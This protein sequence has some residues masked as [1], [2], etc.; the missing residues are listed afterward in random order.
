M[1][2]TVITLVL[3]S[4]PLVLVGCRGS[5]QQNSLWDDVK[6]GDLDTTRQD[7]AARAG[8]IK[9]NNFDVHIYEIPADN[10][11]R[12]AD[13]WQD[14]DA[15][16]MRFYN[17]RAFAENHFRAGLGRRLRWSGIE[18]LIRAA[19]GMKMATIALLLGKT[20]GQ[21]LRI[22]GFDNPLELTFVDR[23]G[24]ID[25]KLI[26]P[27]VFGLRFAAASAPGR[28]ACE[29]VGYPVFSVPVPAAEGPM[30]EYAKSREIEFKGAGFGAKMSK[31]DFIVLGPAQYVGELQT[32][33]GLVFTNLQGTVFL[34]KGRRP[35]RNISVRLFVIVC[36]ATAY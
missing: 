33:G 18:D 6:I 9:T 27:G 32:L 34:E 21:D 17:Y 12:I 26:G 11:A 23:G 25:R 30:A 35:A 10:F 28:D 3:A 36:K 19:G 22:T 5:R 7:N 31:D 13:I 15:Q 20:G 24:A 29:I 16:H 14:L 2:Q 8:Q 1:K 4:L